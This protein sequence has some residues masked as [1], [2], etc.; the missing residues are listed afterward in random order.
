MTFIFHM[1]IQVT[2][3]RF[4]NRFAFFFLL[5]SNFTIIDST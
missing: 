5:D 1:C 2:E 3:T 4:K